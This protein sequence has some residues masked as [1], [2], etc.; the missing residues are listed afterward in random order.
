MVRRCT[1]DGW[2]KGRSRQ[3]SRDRESSQVNNLANMKTLFIMKPFDGWSSSSCKAIVSRS[4]LKVSQP[5]RCAE[6]LENGWARSL[7]RGFKQ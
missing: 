1:G 7:Q 3:G 4:S 6:E 5:S 2:V